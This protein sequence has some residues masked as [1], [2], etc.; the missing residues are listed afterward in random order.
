MN[1]IPV[2]T[3]SHHTTRLLA[4]TAFAGALFQIAGGI[5]ETLD[6]V[7]PTQPGFVLRTSIIGIAYLMLSAGVLGLAR[8]KAAG[9]GLPARLGLATAG[10]GWLLSCV[11][12][13]VL[14]VDFDLAGMILLPIAT[15]ALGLGMIVA[16]V[17]VIRAGLWRGWRRGI[18]LMCGLYPFLVIFPSFAAMAEPV[19]LVL[20]GHGIAWAVLALAT[21]PRKPRNDQAT[22][23]DRRAVVAH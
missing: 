7:P 10:L 16:G 19:F 6:P 4:A 12:Q 3:T 1:T 8:S 5:V 22:A 13:F 14:Q 18:P 17:G 20:S 21:L 15:A 2:T 23:H 11:A 9:S